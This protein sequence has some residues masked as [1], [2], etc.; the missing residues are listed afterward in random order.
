MRGSPISLFSN[1]F[2]ITKIKGL[3]KA[4]PGIELNQYANFY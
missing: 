4:P 2:E 3:L 1:R